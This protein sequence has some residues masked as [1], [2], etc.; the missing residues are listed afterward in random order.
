VNAWFT[1]DFGDKNV[2]WEG[3]VDFFL[4]VFAFFTVILG[5]DFFEDIEGQTFV[6]LKAAVN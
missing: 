1:H 5:L 6:F 4:L 2:A 3:R